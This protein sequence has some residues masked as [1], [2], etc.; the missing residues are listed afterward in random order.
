MT[1]IRAQAG[2]GICL[3]VA[4]STTLVSHSSVLGAPG[5]PANSKFRRSADVSLQANGELRGQVLDQQGRPQALT[6]VAILQNQKLVGYAKTDVAGRFTVR[7]Q[8][9]GAYQIQSAAGVKSVRLWAPQT[10]PPASQHA[11]L[12][13]G[14]GPTARAQ[15]DIQQYGPAIR[16]AV[17]GGLLTGLTYWA[18]DYNSDDAS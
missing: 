16:G 7:G 10:A 3:L 5:Q 18:L 2:R 14:E 11:I 8:K 4:L 13:V 12:L 6:K 17:A 15:V 1:Y 9:P